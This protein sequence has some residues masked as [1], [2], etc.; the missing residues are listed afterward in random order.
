MR[1][2]FLYPHETKEWTRDPFT[3]HLEKCN[4]PL[5]NKEELIEISF[6][7]N[8]KSLSKM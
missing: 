6:D 2:H 5:A 3:V 4:L 1:Q 7:K 8:L